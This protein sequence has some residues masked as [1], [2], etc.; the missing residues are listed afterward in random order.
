MKF[1]SIKKSATLF[2]IVLVFIFEKKTERAI[3]KM[4]P[5]KKEEREGKNTCSLKY[6]VN[7]I[8]KK[9]P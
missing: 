8:K 6:G 2:R 1:E 9:L 7:T 3:E 4:R 5:R